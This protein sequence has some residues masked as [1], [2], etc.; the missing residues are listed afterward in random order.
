MKFINFVQRQKELLQFFH[1][2]KEVTIQDSSLRILFFNF[3]SAYHFEEKA[4]RLNSWDK[5]SSIAENRSFTYPV[6]FHKGKEKAKEVIILLHGLNERNWDK[7]LCW[8]EYLA[9]HTGKAVMLFPIAYHINRAPIQWSDPR[10]MSLLVKKRQMDV[11][12]DH[13]LCF[14]NVALSERLSENPVRFY[15]SGRQTVQ[16]LTDLARQIKRGEHPLFAPDT[17][18]DFFAYSI[19]AFLSEITL[20]ANPEKLFD[21]SKLFIFCGGAIFK[22]MFGESRCIMDKPAY[23]R[24]L[25]FYC[26]EWLSEESIGHYDESEKNDDTLNAFNAMIIP[27]INRE[28]REGF[29]SNLGSRLSGISLKKDLVMPF[30]GVEACVGHDVAAKNF[31]LTDFPYEYTHEAPFPTNGRVDFSLINHSFNAIFSKAAFFLG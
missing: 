24:L 19:G 23:E 4:D 1:L 10:S 25:Q 8:A 22:Y 7:Y 21:K 31:I 12:K 20:M 2:G 26:K 14:A 5:E 15:T 30:S 18:V 28:K 11:G 9:T 6:F 27:E 16:D 29:F 3:E 17:S 13:S